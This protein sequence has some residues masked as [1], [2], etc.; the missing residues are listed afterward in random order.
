MGKLSVK[1]IDTIGQMSK[2]EKAS[3]IAWCCCIVASPLV[4]WLTPDTGVTAYL[5]AMIPLAAAWTIA[6][7]MCGDPCGRT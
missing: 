3:I 1:V 2:V 7:V 5:E 4:L 6:T